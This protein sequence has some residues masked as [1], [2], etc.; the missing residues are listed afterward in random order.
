M[1]KFSHQKFWIIDGKQVWL[2]TGN[3]G[4]TD[5]PDGSGRFPPYKGNESSW[6][7]VNRDFTIGI[8]S[9]D[10]VGVF[11][12]V[13]DQDYERGHDFKPYALEDLEPTYLSSTR[14]QFFH[15][16]E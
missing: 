14:N 10:A 7:D 8:T 15:V 16:L 5:Y 9:S 3:W 13:L 2:S 4:E 1:Y 6:R 12:N 11:K